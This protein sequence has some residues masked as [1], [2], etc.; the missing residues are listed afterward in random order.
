[1]DGCYCKGKQGTPNRHMMCFIED[2]DIQIQ[3]S[4]IISVKLISY[5]KACIT[6]TTFHCPFH[7]LS[8]DSC[9][10]FTPPKSNNS[11]Q[12]VHSKAFLSTKS[13]LR[14]LF[15]DPS[16]LIIS[17]PSEKASCRYPQ[18]PTATSLLASRTLFTIVSGKSHHILVSSSLGHS[19]TIF[20]S[21][22]SFTRFSICNGN[23]LLCCFWRT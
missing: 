3:K 8:K 14:F 7:V 9:K 15:T 12:M 13:G 11:V 4:L 16:F 19:W 2:L 10:M 1:M 22:F 5:V 23:A 18:H 20:L 6:F 21:D 17:L